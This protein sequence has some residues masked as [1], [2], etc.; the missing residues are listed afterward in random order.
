MFYIF[1]SQIM[2]WRN[3]SLQAA[4][5]HYE[6]I[7]DLMQRAWWYGGSIPQP[8]QLIQFVIP[9]KAPLLDNFWT[10][11]LFNLYSSSLIS[12]FRSKGI[13]FDTFPASISRKK[14]GP[15]VNKAYELFRLLETKDGVDEQRTKYQEINF[16]S[17]TVKMIEHLYLTKS[18]TENNVPMTRL[19]NHTHLT[20]VNSE[21]KSAI[22]NSELTGCLFIP[23]DEYTEI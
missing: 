16:K 2:Q 7:Y 23:I 19:F 1:K 10:G 22:E 17:G 14:T 5:S 13:N 12:I 18:F 4:L 8:L 20:I 3:G 9:E 15:V 11:T 6:P 21:I